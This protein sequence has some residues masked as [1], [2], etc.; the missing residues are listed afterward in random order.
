MSP[1][2]SKNAITSIHAI[3]TGSGE[4]HSE[5]RHGS[6]VPQLWWVLTSRSWIRVPI[7][8]FAIEHLDG[9][10]LFDTGMDPAIA[11]NPHYV[12]SALGRFLLN[13]IFRL[14]ISPGDGLGKQL[15]TVGLMSSD[16]KKVVISHLHFDH[17]GGIAD[18]PQADFLISQDEWRLLSD[19]HPERLWILREHIELPGIQWRRIKFG[20]S[21]DPLLAP[22]G[23]CH[24]VMGDG[25]LILLPT[26]GHTPGS[27]S[28]LVQSAGMKPLLLVADLTYETQLLMQGKV[29]GTGDAQILRST[30]AKV[31]ALKAKMPDLVILASH[32]SKTVETLKVATTGLR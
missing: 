17:I 15:E 24:D 4:Q 13:R 19:P 14:H 8:C 18:V 3:S 12:D 23:G 29:P 10:V 32:D 2:F 22:F 28:L 31:R 9:L 11:S 21:D 1:S 27:M 7:L 26:P 20:P 6:W 25:S 5:H 30:Y 16:V